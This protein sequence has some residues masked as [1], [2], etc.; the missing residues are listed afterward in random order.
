MKK[1]KTGKER[2]HGEQYRNAHDIRQRQPETRLKINT[3]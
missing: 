3:Q 1:L 2:I